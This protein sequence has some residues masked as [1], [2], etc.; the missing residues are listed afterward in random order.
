[1]SNAS[2]QAAPLM[3]VHWKKQDVARLQHILRRIVR[4]T[5]R[6]AN[7]AVD[8]ATTRFLI[9]ARAGMHKGKARR[10]IQT[11]SRDPNYQFYRVFRQGRDKPV[12]VWVPPEGRTNKRGA[13][14]QTVIRRFGK[15]RTAGA[16]KASFNSAMRDHARASGLST[17]RPTKSDIISGRVSRTQHRRSEIKTITTSTLRYLRKVWPSLSIVAMRRATNA[18]RHNLD[19]NASPKIAAIWNGAS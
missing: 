12:N 4:E 8:W 11:S 15:I 16:G 3:F 14:R 13:D 7:E 17:A 19:R 5:P 2:A 10:A 6:I 9:S 18:L 1:M